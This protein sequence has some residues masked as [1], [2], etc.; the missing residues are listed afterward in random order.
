MRS[1]ML[2]RPAALALVLSLGGCL[3]LG[4]AKAPDE[5]FTLT[6]EKGATAGAAA[7][8]K[9]GDAIMVMEPE[10]DRR[11]AVQRVPVQID[12][13]RVAYLK[14][15]MWVERPTRLFRS[16]LAERLRGAGGRLVL[17]DDQPSTMVGQRLSGRLL[18]MGYDAREQAVVVRFE[19]LR[20]MPDG[21]IATRRFESV[22]R[23]VSPKPEQVGPAL[24]KAANV[25]AAQVVEWI[26][27]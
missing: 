17:E 14:K 18:D 23:G 24:N 21:T 10:A 15:A 27:S 4:G 16:L 20:T 19:A 5:L 9:P 7:S 13:A 11:L 25:V 22:A 2:L 1:A 26:G 6:A 3:S 12:A 8:A